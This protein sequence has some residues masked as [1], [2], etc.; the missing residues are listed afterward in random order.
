[1]KPEVHTVH[2]LCFLIAVQYITPVQVFTVDSHYLMAW[3]A[4]LH[5][6]MN[7]ISSFAG[8]MFIDPCNKSHP[9]TW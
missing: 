6:Q 1:M 4:C 9:K 5:F 8:D 7:H 3:T 2:V